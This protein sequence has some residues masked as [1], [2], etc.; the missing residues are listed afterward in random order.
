LPY[1]Q[2]WDEDID[3]AE[4][5]PTASSKYDCGD[6]FDVD[7]EA[8]IAAAA[9]EGVI[10]M[11][12]AAISPAVIVPET[13]P[14]RVAN[15][16]IATPSS[17]LMSNEEKEAVTT[18]ELKQDETVVTA[19][20]M[21]PSPCSQSA[22]SDII[23]ESSDTSVDTE[24]VPAAAPA[25]P[26]SA[27]VRPTASAFMAMFKTGVASKKSTV[28]ESFEPSSPK[29][30]AAQQEKTSLPDS[31]SSI[32]SSSSLT[33][34]EDEE[35]ESSRIALKFLDDQA[36]ESDGEDVAKSKREDEEEEVRMLLQYCIQ[37]LK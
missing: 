34:E 8:L 15:N 24:A 26:K 25:A 10:Q 7:V 1:T 3:E 31:A 20:D 32:S 28:S 23:C 9:A 14:I 6:D 18:V 37:P 5:A 33:S 12:A 35:A 22:A 17:H 19:V 30:T 4:A 36:E 16:A 27:S 13:N 29:A 2:R 21:A 11:P